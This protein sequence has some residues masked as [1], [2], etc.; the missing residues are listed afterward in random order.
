RILSKTKLAPEI[1]FN[2]LDLANKRYPKI[3]PSNFMLNWI[4]SKN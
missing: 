1:I 4:L 2:P 3:A